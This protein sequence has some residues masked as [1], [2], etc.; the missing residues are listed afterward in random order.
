VF[1]LEG[2][3]HAGAR[4]N[5]LHRFQLSERK[6]QEF[7][8]TVAEYAI[9]ADGKKL[10]YRTPLRPRPAAI[11]MRRRRVR[12]L[13]LVDADKKDPPK[14]GDGRL[15][16]NAADASRSEGRVHPDLQRGLAPAA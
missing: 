10:V 13:F 12:K 11:R 4:G 1:F 8:Q 9:S 7:Q 5:I 3:R 16:V 6:A 15:D 2:A 14:A